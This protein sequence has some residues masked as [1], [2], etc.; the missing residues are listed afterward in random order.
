MPHNP[1]GTE[2]SNGGTYVDHLNRTNGL[3]GGEDWPLSVGTTLP[4]P[5]AGRLVVS[6]GSGEFAAGWQGSAGI[7]VILMLDT[8]I[9]DVIAVVFQHLSA[10]GSAGDYAEGQS[11]GLSGRSANGSLTGGQ[12]HLHLHCLTA[13]GARRQ[14]TR[15]FAVGGGPPP[16]PG[17]GSDAA[18]GNLYV[19]PVTKQLYRIVD[20]GTEHGTINA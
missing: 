16:N 7:R 3:R 18:P 11:V 6:G 17:G 1:Y 8:P 9:N 14:F 5:A 2:L 12:Q 20:D 15:Y 19:H 13:S 4:A 10:P